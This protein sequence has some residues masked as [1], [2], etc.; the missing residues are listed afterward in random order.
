MLHNIYR[1][2]TQ[3]RRYG[4][5]TIRISCKIK[6]NRVKL[7]TKPKAGVSPNETKI[8]CTKAKSHSA[9]PPQTIIRAKDDY[10]KSKRIDWVRAHT[11]QAVLCVSQLYWTEYVT[12]AIKTSPEAL[13]EYYELNN[14]QIDDIVELV[15]GK[16]NMQNRVTLGALVVLDVHAR[17]VLKEL[18]E[19]GLLEC[20]LHFYSTL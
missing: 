10:T 16:L 12:Q 18:C 8:S 19:K 13:N 17:D 3:K 4:K 6:P 9:I 5:N 7:G 1:T 15:R 11:G 20:L 2:E 14:R